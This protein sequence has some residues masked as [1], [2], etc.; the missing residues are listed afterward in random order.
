MA[1]KF[2]GKR[3]PDKQPN[4]QTN[5]FPFSLYVAYYFESKDET[6]IENI[7]IKGI[8]GLESVEAISAVILK[9][10]EQK[11][12]PDF[13]SRITVMNWWRITDDRSED[14]T[15]PEFLVPPAEPEEF[16]PPMAAPE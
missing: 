5:M 1:R 7:V 2:G 13:Y 6:G 9:I 8:S 16:K 4:P 15:V 12:D 11:P 10:K 14:I 3:L